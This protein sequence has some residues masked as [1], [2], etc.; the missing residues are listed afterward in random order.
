MITVSPIKDERAVR[1][2][3]DK[4]G[5]AFSDVCAAVCAIEGGVEV[6]CGLF[7]LDGRDLTLLFVDFPETDVEICELITRAVMNYGVNRGTLDCGLGPASPKATLVS[8]GFIPDDTATSMNI[9]HVFTHCTHC[10]DNKKEI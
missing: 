10:H 3:F 5:I 4:H 8:L 1:A 2:L 9:I 7:A 6:G